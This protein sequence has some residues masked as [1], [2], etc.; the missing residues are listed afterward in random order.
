MMLDGC[1]YGWVQELEDF[2]RETPQPCT[3]LE[4][5]DAVIASTHASELWAPNLMELDYSV[6]N[7]DMDSSIGNRGMSLDIETFLD[8]SYDFLGLPRKEDAQNRH[9]N[10]SNAMVQATSSTPAINYTF[11]PQADS[12]G[13]ATLAIPRLT[14]SLKALK[15]VQRKQR[16]N[17]RNTQGQINPWND[18]TYTTVFRIEKQK[19][20][21]RTPAENA[22]KRLIAK[23]GQCIPCF[24]SKTKVCKV[25][26]KAP[27]IPRAYLT[28]MSTFQC[29]YNPENPSECCAKCLERS[30]R[31]SL[32]TARL[33]CTRIYLSEDTFSLRAQWPAELS[34][35]GMEARTRIEMNTIWNL[36]MAQASIVAFEVEA[37]QHSAII[38]ENS[39]GRKLARATFGADAVPSY[40][41]ST[42]SGIMNPG[43]RP[44]VVSFPGLPIV[45]EVSGA[46]AR[47][48]LR[49]LAILVDLEALNLLLKRFWRGQLEQHD[50]LDIVDAL[51]TLQCWCEHEDRITRNGAGDQNGL[52]KDELSL[53]WIT[54]WRYIIKSQIVTPLS[55][56]AQIMQTRL[57]KTLESSL[58]L[59][60][61]QSEEFIRREQ[62]SCDL[63]V[64]STSTDIRMQN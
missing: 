46:E 50:A 1:G 27:I 63:G 6:C 26:Q 4:S 33:P 18:K 19:Q 53:P 30:M 11:V 24:Q 61:I 41:A 47:P 29:S 40:N 13:E 59:R 52:P 55:A 32:S 2:N 28:S 10:P 34:N 49:P 7:L 64:S 22:N 37:R 20:R 58:E 9:S 12:F 25:I 8:E 14:E 17:S 16:K 39:P 23:Y 48:K 36:T 3:A 42:I 21:P 15:I 54:Y 44:I 62:E 56:I 51:Y 45:V 38:S 60:R 57:P 31:S 43:A 35:V 5:S